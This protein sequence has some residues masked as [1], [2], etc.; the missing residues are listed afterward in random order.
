MI[1][2]IEAGGKGGGLDAERLR[3][4]FRNTALWE[5]QVTT[6]DSGHASVEL[7]LPDNLTTWR[8]QARA[9][10]GPATVGE[11]ES[12]LL[13]TQPLLIRPALP[14]FLR[15]GDESILRVLVR[16]ATASTVPAEVTLQAEGLEVSGPATKTRLIGPSSSE[17]FEWPAS[18]RVAGE[19]TLTFTS[20]AGGERDAVR[21]P[22]QVLLDVTPETTATG[23]IVTDEPGEEVIYLPDFA[24]LDGG[25]LEVNVQASLVG[26]LQDE[27]YHLRR[28]WL[29]E[30][31]I[32]IASRVMAT[33]GVKRG[34]AG[35]GPSVSAGDIAELCR[36]QN[37]D[38]GFRWGTRA[39]RSDPTITA[40]ALLAFGESGAARGSELISQVRRAENYL[41]G[42]IDRPSDVLRPLDRNEH[43]FWLYTLARAGAEQR[44][45][46]RAIAQQRRAELTNP[47][48]AYVLLGL[49]YSGVRDETAVTALLNDL[50]ADAISSA[51]GTHWED[52]ETPRS[53]HTSTRTT[54]AVVHALAELGIDHTLLD[55]S[56]RWLTVAR[57]AQ[58]GWQSNTE[59]AQ[60]IAAL[61]TFA[62]GTGEFAGDY[63]YDV[64][65]NGASI[66]DGHFA[67]AVDDSGDNTRVALDRLPLGDVSLLSLTRQFDEPGRLYYALNLRYFTAAAQIDALNRGIAVSHTY[68]LLDAPDESL[69][70]VQLGDVVRVTVTVV[71]PA[72][73]KFVVLNDHLP[74]G[75]EPIDPSLAI[76]PADLRRQLEDE[77]RD[78][79]RST[80]GTTIAP[81]YRW[82]FNPWE[83]VD[84]RD[85]HVEL[86]ATNLPRGVHEYVYFARAT[87][88]G[89]YFV[90][91]AE[92]HEEFFPEVFG[93]SDSSRFVI[94]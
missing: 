82:Y 79:I 84:I 58:R 74:G 66:L 1:A 83:H 25:D 72:D 92:I 6:D 68:S 90:A 73:R 2:E 64:V 48:R 55:E 54:A 9:I 89:D 81:W 70:R 87:S 88:P 85:E 69:D 15:V 30:S 12:E 51:N 31:T 59:R 41:L 94:E 33:A 53:V 13:V 29:P 46:L 26:V 86:F 36:R 76:I 39:S 21:L 19:A 35:L 77:R 24:L 40:F 91:P 4:D 27:L 3:Q 5:A 65:L 28:H 37:A 11:G 71:T 80:S 63:D 18:A 52:E 20:E 57:T 50:A 14:R 60:A 93:R 49:V 16:N 67:P 8:A 22:L 34:Q 61:G 43:A 7:R 38:G 62:G 17:I 56:V 47:G 78:A 44:S 23:G 75:L 45:R 10:T 32:K 42:E